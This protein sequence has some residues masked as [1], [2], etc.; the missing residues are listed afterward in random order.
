MVDVGTVCDVMK[1]IHLNRAFVAQGLK[2]LGQRKNLG[3]K[4]LCDVA[5]LNEKPNCYP[6]SFFWVSSR[7]HSS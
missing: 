7:I 3:M 2:I 1:L 4:T 5:G 6:V